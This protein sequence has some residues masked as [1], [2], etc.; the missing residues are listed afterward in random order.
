MWI[1]FVQAGIMRTE[2]VKSEDTVFYHFE[3]GKVHREMILAHTESPKASEILKRQCE[4][5]HQG[6]TLEQSGVAS[7]PL[8]TQERGETSEQKDKEKIR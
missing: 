8:A 1:V 4:R 6:K 5:R 2:E 7:P 3:G